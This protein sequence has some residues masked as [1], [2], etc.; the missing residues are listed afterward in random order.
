MPSAGENLREQFAHW[1]TSAKNPYFAKSYVNRA[2]S[3]LLG[4]GFIDPIDDIRAGNPATN[5]ELLDRLTADFIAGG[6]DI[7]NLQR[8]ICKSRIYQLSITT[9]KWNEEDTVNYSHALARRLPAEALYD[10]VFQVTGATRQLSGMPAGTRAAE[11]RDP[12]VNAPDGFLDLFGRPAR[13]SSCE[14]E[15]SS[16]V[17]LGQALNLINGPTVASAII[18]P[19]NGIFQLVAS[20]KDDAKLVEEIFFRILNRPPMG[21]ELAASLNTLKAFDDDHAK[22]GAELAAYE[23]ALPAKQA[24]WEKS[25]AAPIWTPLEI[26]IAKSSAGATLSKEADGTIFASGKLAKDKYTLVAA[27]DLAG[28]TGVRLEALADP[29]LPAGGPGRAPGNGNQV[30]SELRLNVAPIGDPANAKPVAL[31]NAQA[32]FNQPGWHVSGAIDGDPATGWALAEQTGKNHVA[33][34][35]CKE[36][37]GAAGGSL[38]IFTLDQQFGDGQHELG[39]FRLS[40]TTSKRPISLEGLPANIAALIAI[41]TDKRSDAQKSELAAHYRSLDAELARLSQAVAQH[42]NDRTNA[43]LMG[44]QDLVWALINSPAFLF[45]R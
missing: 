35:E 18:E 31:Q 33:V 27:T 37:I 4:P 42:A 43:R 10:A 32:D 24:E 29:R 2:W 45:N 11:E 13:Q 25:V 23:K 12:S 3:Y 30:L 19:N 34:F 28:I 36:N 8:F 9:N 14:C 44:T 26:A 5:P 7:Q 6:F 17:M 22:L 39:K 1:A 16:G 21:T 41:P 15:R 20:E 38:L 40:V